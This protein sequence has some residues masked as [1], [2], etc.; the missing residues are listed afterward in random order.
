M[1]M[2][3]SRDAGKKVARSGRLAGG[4]L[5]RLVRDGDRL[6]IECFVVDLSRVC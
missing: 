2:F 6:W 3:E 1:Y 5:Y 4:V